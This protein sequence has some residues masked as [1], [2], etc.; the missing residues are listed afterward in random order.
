VIIDAVDNSGRSACTYAVLAG[1]AW[2]VR[3]LLLAGAS[4]NKLTAPSSPSS[5]SPPLTSLALSRMTTGP[6]NNNISSEGQHLR[7][8]TVVVN[9]T[10]IT[11]ASHGFADNGRDSR[12]TSNAS[13]DDRPKTDDGRDKR[14]RIDTS[15]DNRP[16]LASSLS[17]RSR[18]RSVSGVTIYGFK[19]EEICTPWSAANILV[20]SNPAIG[21]FSVLLSRS[22]LIF[23]R[24]LIL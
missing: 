21:M 10:D 24:C 16:K 22:L 3:E 14:P 7:T 9:D 12:L 1:N 20:L 18:D 23:S 17:N 19:N 5:P 11:A 15:Q 2:I 8:N 13:Q 4:V 6:N